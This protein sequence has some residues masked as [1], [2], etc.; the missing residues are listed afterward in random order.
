MSLVKEYLSLTYF[1]IGNL[2]MVNDIQNS[3]LSHSCR[4]IIYLNAFDFV[5]ASI[6]ILKCSTLGETCDE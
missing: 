5:T 4:H 6:L 2:D 3:R 1:V